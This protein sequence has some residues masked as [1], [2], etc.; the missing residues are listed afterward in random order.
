MKHTQQISL[1]QIIR[2]H[3]SKVIINTL[4]LI[5]E[6]ALMSLVP[7]FIGFAIDDLLNK[8][9]ND[10]FI[11]ISVLA[12]L[13]VVSVVRR[14]Y[15]TRAYGE[16]RVSVQEEIVDRNADLATSVL[17]ARL[18]MA[19]EL[20][21]FLEENV[22]QIL[23]AVVQFIVSLTVLYFLNPML[24]VAALVSAVAMIIIYSMFHNSFYLI[25]KTYN[26]QTE[27][28]VSILDKRSLSVARI[29]FQRLMKLEIKLSDRE[30][31]LYGAV[32]FVLVA[33]VV[34][35]LWYSTLFGTISAG[36]IFSIVSYSWEF[37]EAAVVLPVTLQSLT[38]LTEITHRI[39]VSETS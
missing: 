24:S 26:S 23:N 18:E 27:R 35:N 29:H 22:A 11:L 28:Q 8:K 32:F 20:V 2:S 21:D 19:R 14:F 38:R 6:I 16:I 25:N 12:S 1:Q 39:N 9:T 37:V 34:F 17:N 13:I 5:V 33:M 36:T 31:L 15:D 4:L 7:L 10:L 30:A 3:K